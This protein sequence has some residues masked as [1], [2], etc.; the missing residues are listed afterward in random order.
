MTQLA[1]ELQCPAKAVGH[2]Q[3]V[4]S[5]MCKGCRTAYNGRPRGSVVGDRLCRDL[6][7]D[8]NVERNLVVKHAKTATNSRAVIAR[9]GKDKAKAWS[10]IDGLSREGIVIKTQT[11]I[12]C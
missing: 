1:I 9:W 7:E 8:R 10:N 5:D 6:V 12:H 11:Q 3:C 4:G 2:M